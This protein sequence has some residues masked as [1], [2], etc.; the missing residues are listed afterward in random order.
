[1]GLC[2]GLGAQVLLICQGRVDRRTV[3]ELLKGGRSLKQIR[4]YARDNRN[5]KNE[6][7]LFCFNRRR[8]G[9]GGGGGE[10]YAN[11]KEPSFYK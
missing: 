11:T 1:M 9:R 7:P 5:I 6:T 2:I 3:V 10:V 4:C 8:Q